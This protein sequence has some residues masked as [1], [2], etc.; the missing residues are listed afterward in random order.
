M[1]VYCITRLRNIK[2]GMKI[3][4]GMTNHLLIL[5]EFN[6][7]PNF[8]PTF[9]IESEMNFEFQIANFKYPQ[10]YSFSQSQFIPEYIQ[11]YVLCRASPS[12]YTTQLKIQI[13]SSNFFIRGFSFYQNKRVIRESTESQIRVI[14]ELFETDDMIKMYL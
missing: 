2:R 11:W 3:I 12:L 9:V 7:R 4:I 6:L 8:S 1:T 14:S 10:L 5:T 13:L